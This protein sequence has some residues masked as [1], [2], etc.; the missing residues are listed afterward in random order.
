MNAA[1]LAKAKRVNRVDLDRFRKSRKH[2]RAKT[3]EAGIPEIKN[4]RMKTCISGSCF[5]RV[6]L[7]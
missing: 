1:W 4:G 7:S 5:R 2:E 6:V 3:R